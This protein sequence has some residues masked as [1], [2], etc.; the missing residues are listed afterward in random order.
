MSLIDEETKKRFC[1]WAEQNEE[2]HI[3]PEILQGESYYIPREDEKTYMMEYSFETVAELGTAMEEYSGLSSGSQILKMLVVEICQKQSKGKAEK[4]KEKFTNE[5]S[6]AEY[7]KTE[8]P[9]FV[10]VF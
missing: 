6:K 8:L 2:R 9:E 5:N 10:Y 4:N 7:Q 3:F 1:Q